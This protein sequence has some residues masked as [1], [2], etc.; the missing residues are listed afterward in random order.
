MFFKKQLTEPGIKIASGKN[1]LISGDG[2]KL[3]NIEKYFT[4]LFGSNIKKTKI[5]G[6]KNKEDL[7]I[8][9]SSCLGALKI[10]KDGW[11][12]EAIP[13]KSDKNNEKISFFAKIFK[14]NN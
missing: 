5:S 3:P 13:E 12:T 4:N 7:E 2:S 8:N 10:I 6:E 14:I 11:E 9:F 1:F